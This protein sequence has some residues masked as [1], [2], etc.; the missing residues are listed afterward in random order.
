[1]RGK[2]EQSGTRARYLRAIWSV[3]E[4]SDAPV[5]VTGLARTL[6]LVP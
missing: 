2:S 3:T 5:T 4:G 1:M 6:R